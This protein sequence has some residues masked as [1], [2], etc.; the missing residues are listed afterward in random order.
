MSFSP[1]YS[2]DCCFY[3]AYINQR[4]CYKQLGLKWCFGSMAYNGWWEYGGKDYETFEDFYK[5]KYSCGY[6]AHSWLEDKDGRVYDFIS[7]KDAFTSRIRTNKDI[8]HRG[9]IE[10]WTKEECANVG[11]TYMPASEKVR[12]AAFLDL[13]PFMKEVEVAFLDGKS[14][15][16]H[17]VG[18]YPRQTD[19]VPYDLF[20]GALGRA[21]LH[22]GA[23]TAPPKNKPYTS[24]F[25]ASKLK[26][27]YDMPL[28]L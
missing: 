6:D 22:V 7:P 17:A 14:Y 21:F 5:G 9:K 25:E 15:T 20:S 12:L 10:G 4:N 18:V 13:L 11:L 28:K 26:K 16:S 2:E 23:Y 3:N 1:V 24:L 19:P 27:G 8:L